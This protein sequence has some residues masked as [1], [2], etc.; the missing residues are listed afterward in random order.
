[1][2]LAENGNDLTK[3]ATSDK[4]LP[5][6][7]R[8]DKTKARQAIKARHEIISNITTLAKSKATDELSAIS[9]SAQSQFADHL[10][11][12][13]GRLQRL[14]AINPNVRD[15]EIQTLIKMKEQGLSALAQLSLVPDSVR[16]LICVKPD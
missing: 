16:I 15:D 3:V 1:M 5:I 11:K 12:E 14:Q 2:L 4:L 6:I 8:L 10:D 13:I 7:A 9:A